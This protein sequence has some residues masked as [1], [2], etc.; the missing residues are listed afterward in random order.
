MDINVGAVLKYYD[1][2][3]VTQYFYFKK[4]KYYA[5]KEISGNGN[6]SKNL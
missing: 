6:V 2:W 5:F 1:F 4:G 3:L